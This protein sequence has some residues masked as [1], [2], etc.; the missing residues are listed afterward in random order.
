M[1]R[2]RVEEPD[3]HS[4]RW[5]ISYA[6]F[7]TLLFAFFVVLYAI[8]SVNEEKYRQVTESFAGIFSGQDGALRP[9]IGGK[10]DSDPAGIGIFQ[11]GE[12][13]RENPTEKIIPPKPENSAALRAIGE[14]ME[15]QFKKLIS[16]GSASVQSNNLWVALEL[17]ANL[18]YPEGGA[19]PVITTD[20]VFERVAKILKQYDNP[21]HVE[22]YTDNQ[23]ISSDE[24]PSNWEL[25]AA[26]AAGVVRILE[27]NGVAP[28]RMAAV[29]FGEYQPHADNDTES[30]RR[31]N[32][33]IMIVVTRD[34]KTQRVV[35]AFGSEQVSEDA[36]SGILTE[37]GLPE[38]SIEP[39]K[40]ERGR[41]IFRRTE[42][43]QPL[44]TE[45]L[46]SPEN[47][48]PQTQESPQ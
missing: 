29:G 7:I 46:M 34:R 26:R 30:G 2:R 8:S 5:V 33:R 6:D 40:D 21:I 42:V 12:S 43:T 22:G 39:V 36:V 1:S 41:V 13:S 35:S 14:Q 11:G 45:T 3:L 15:M 48:S 17:G 9:P 38:S 27:M 10:S 23:F 18:V 31:I 4:Q 16:N 24:Y 32:R 20:P 44:D 37:S 28:Q 19:L 25:S 47:I